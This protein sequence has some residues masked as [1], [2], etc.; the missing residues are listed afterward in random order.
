MSDEGKQGRWSGRNVTKDA[1]RADVW[2]NLEESGTSIG[3]VWSAIPNFEG[4]D[5]ADWW[6]AQTP[7][8]KAVRTVKCNPDPPQI[9]VRLRA[10]YDGKI[11]YAPVPYL[12]K[13]FPYLRLD[14][15]A[16]QKKGVSFE[17]AATSE[18]YMA[19]DERIEFEQVKLLEFLRCWQRGCD[20]LWRT[21]G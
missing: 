10:L 1:A 15:A 7:E 3:P 13:E 20:A 8:W 19:H 2:Q 6:L 14:P 9:P 5:T 12:T 18:G 17:L 11:V 21:Q 4:A 16:L